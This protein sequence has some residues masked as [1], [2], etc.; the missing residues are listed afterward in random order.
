MNT[1]CI[2]IDHFDRGIDPFH[3]MTDQL[4]RP[5]VPAEECMGSS[6]SHDAETVSKIRIFESRTLG[7]DTHS[8]TVFFRS[9]P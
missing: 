6:V 8:K 5:D 9:R 3:T 1:E 2:G 7:T 4:D